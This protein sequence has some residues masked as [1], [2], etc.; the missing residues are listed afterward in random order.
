MQITIHTKKAVKTTRIMD[1]NRKS[2]EQ[3]W[4]VDIDENWYKL[5]IPCERSDIID[6]KVDGESIKH[7]LNAGLD[8]AKGYEIWLHGN[9]AEYFSRISNCIAH[10]DLMRYKHLDTKYLITESWNES[11]EGEFIPNHV[12]QFF[13]KGEGPHWYSKTDFHNLPY[14]KYNGLEVSKELGLEDL[15][16]I[17]S[18][19]YGEGQCK[20]LQRLPVMPMRNVAD[21]KNDQLKHTLQQFGFSKVLQVQYVELQPNSVIPVHRDDFTYE[22]G[23]HVIDGPTQLYFVL[24]GDSSKIKFKFRNVGL[25]PTDKPIFINNHRFIHSLVYTGDEPRGVL[26]VFGISELTNKRFIC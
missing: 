15:T 21:L 12:K 26:L 9:L 20:S 23:K 16:F 17:D 25:V 13:A 5:T 3:V 6:I 19:F 2:S 10:D 4:P 7:G 24:S 1:L 18:K 22:D 8:T 14:V 11:V